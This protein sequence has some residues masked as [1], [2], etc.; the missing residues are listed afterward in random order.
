LT[1][2]I[3]SPQDGTSF[4][5]DYTLSPDG[6]TAS[7]VESGLLIPPAGERAA[8]SANPLPRLG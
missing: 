5:D 8:E 7:F 1:G 4:R 3:A 2:S 6:P